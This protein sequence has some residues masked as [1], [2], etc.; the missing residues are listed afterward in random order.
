MSYRTYQDNKSKHWLIWLFS[1]WQ[2]LPAIQP[3]LVAVSKTKPADMVIEAYSHG[4]RTFGE[5]YVCEGPFPARKL[6][7]EE[8]DVPGFWLT[9]FFTL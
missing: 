5:N 7:S 6:L 4:Q 9:L 8:S 3:R 1:S 2:D